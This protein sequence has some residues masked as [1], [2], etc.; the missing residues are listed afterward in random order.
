MKPFPT[1][2]FVKKGKLKKKI[3]GVAP[4]PFAGRGLI[5]AFQIEELPPPSLSFMGFLLVSKSQEVS[6]N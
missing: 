2:S 4:P 3:F 6:R 5:E 1:L